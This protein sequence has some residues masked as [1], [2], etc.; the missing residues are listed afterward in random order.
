METTAWIG[1]G[2]LFL[3]L[4]VSTL[5]QLPSAIER[6]LRRHDY[7]GLIPHWNFFAPRPGMWDYHLVYRDR[8]ADGTITRWTE[9]DIVD[10][11]RPWHAVWNPRRRQKKSF[12]DLVTQLM[13]NSLELPP[14]DLVLTVSYLVL[15][16]WVSSFP[17]SDGATAT[18]F[19]VVF[20]YGATSD[21]PAQPALV[22]ALHPL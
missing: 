18:Q 17:R 7:A 4:L 12:H 15:L 3:W 10:P 5:C 11:R 21:E 9:V 14:D 2:L 20:G 13:R 16:T 19:A 6:G 22:S 1:F 8:L